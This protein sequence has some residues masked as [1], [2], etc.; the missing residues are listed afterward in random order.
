[1]NNKEL[2]NKFTRVKKSDVKIFIQVKS[3]TWNVQTPEIHWHTILCLDLGT[4]K[5]TIDKEREHLLYNNKY[6]SVCE[7]CGS[8]NPNGWMHGMMNGKYICQTCAQLRGVIY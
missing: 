5:S 8:R 4:P 7:E 3:I 2:I 1:M 6:F